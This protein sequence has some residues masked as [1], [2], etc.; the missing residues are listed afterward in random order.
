[1]QRN[2]DLSYANLKKNCIGI[3]ECRHSDISQESSDY[4]RQAKKLRNNEIRISKT[5]VAKEHCSAHV[6]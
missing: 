5:I 6:C 2:N 4:A 3:T 1:M